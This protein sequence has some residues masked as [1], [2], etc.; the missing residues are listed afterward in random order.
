[1]A[2]T[3]LMNLMAPTLISLRTSVTPSMLETQLNLASQAAT[4]RVPTTIFHTETTIN[5]DWVGSAL[6]KDKTTT[7]QAEIATAITKATVMP[8]QIVTVMDVTIIMTREANEDTVVM[9]GGKEITIVLVI[10]NSHIMWRKI[11][12]ALAPNPR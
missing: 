6:M 8:T 1:M 4:L 7:T 12:V 9:A 2:V 10:K 5:I 3:Q 11:E